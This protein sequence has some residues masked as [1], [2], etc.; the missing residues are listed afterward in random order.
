VEYLHSLKERPKTLFATHYHELT[1][2]SEILDLGKNYHITVREWQDNVVF[3]HKIAPGATDQSF[4]IH[5]AKIDRRA[6]A[7]D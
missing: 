4:G 3:L 2:L 6:R 7:G 5:V 1:E